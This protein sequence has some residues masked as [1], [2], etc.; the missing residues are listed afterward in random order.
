M[1]SMVKNLSSVKRV[2]VGSR[3]NMRNKNYKSVIKTM[4][5]K[6]LLELD[7]R[8]SNDNFNS[9]RLN[10]L[11]AQVYSKIDKAVKKGV[12]HKSSAAR[13]KSILANRLKLGNTFKSL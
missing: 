10:V 3:N 6:L 1:K 11:I 2:Q 8:S 7:N 12:M 13:K 4:T 9:N 5:R